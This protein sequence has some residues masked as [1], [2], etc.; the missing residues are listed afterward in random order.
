MGYMP[1]RYNNHFGLYMDERGELGGLDVRVL[2]RRGKQGSGSAFRH[3]R[4]EER[5]IQAAAARAAK[6]F[7][8]DAGGKG[9]WGKDASHS[10]PPA[11]SGAKGSKDAWDSAPLGAAPR[12]R[13]ARTSPQI[14]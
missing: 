8:K 4:H 13:A 5:K 2:K 10:T 7:G 9:A 6:W 12:A 11:W 1:I 14:S 3:Q